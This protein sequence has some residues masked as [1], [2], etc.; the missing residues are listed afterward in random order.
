MSRVDQ[1]LQC[2]SFLQDFFGGF[3]LSH[4][5]VTSH[6]RDADAYAIPPRATHERPS[7]LDW[8]PKFCEMLAVE[9]MFLS[10]S[11]DLLSQSSNSS[12]SLS[13]LR[14]TAL[15]C[16]LD[17]LPFWLQRAQVPSQTQCACHH[18][19]GGRVCWWSY[20]MLFDA[21]S[22]HSLKQCSFELPWDPECIFTPEV[23]RA[24]VGEAI[25]I[26]CIE[27]TVLSA[28]CTGRSM[29]YLVFWMLRCNCTLV[30]TI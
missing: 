16:K 10:R 3:R 6:L 11:L 17:G 8:V 20:W 25:Y 5:E 4:V 9:D 27:Y 13:G 29:I 14:F 24:S 18:Q 28:D 1:L 26:L 22:Q 12:L 15:P 23:W 7:F 2:W 19:F 21:S 30:V